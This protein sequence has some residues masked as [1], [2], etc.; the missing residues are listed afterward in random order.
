MIISAKDTAALGPSGIKSSFLILVCQD[1]VRIGCG[2]GVS[3]GNPAKRAL[4]LPA[5]IIVDR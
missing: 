1:V 2:P 5:G 4:C 3:G